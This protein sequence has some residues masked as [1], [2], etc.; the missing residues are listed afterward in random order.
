MGA[1]VNKGA[2]AVGNTGNCSAGGTTAEVGPGAVGNT[3]DNFSA[4]AVDTGAG[5]GAALPR[6]PDVCGPGTV[7]PQV[8]HIRLALEK[9]AAT[10]GATDVLPASPVATITFGKTK[11][12]VFVNPPL[13]AG[14]N[15]ACCMA[16]AA[17]TLVPDAS[18]WPWA[19]F[20]DGLALDL[21]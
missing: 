18:R 17:G 5:I 9:F 6:N 1:A 4:G 2:D 15:V 7:V 14:G 8:G 13:V 20:S 12:C 10:C 11:P 19:G 21:N 16:G 3:S